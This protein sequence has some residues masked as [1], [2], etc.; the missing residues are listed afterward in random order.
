MGGNN[1]EDPFERKEDAILFIVTCKRVMTDSIRMGATTICM[2]FR[3]RPLRKYDPAVSGTEWSIIQS[4]LISS[5]PA[6]Y[7]RQSSRLLEEISSNR[8]INI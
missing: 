8:M 7:C 2:V 4:L 6:N 3:I 5:K 1:V